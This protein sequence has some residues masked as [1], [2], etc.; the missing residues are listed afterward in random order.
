MSD[1]DERIAKLP[2]WAREH[3]KR[4]TDAPET[5]RRTLVETNA[6]LAHAN[7][8]IRTVNDRLDAVHELLKCAARGG[9]ETARAYVDR[10]VAE[11]AADS[12]R[13][14]RI[15]A[16]MAHVRAVVDAVMQHANASGGVN[17]S[18]ILDR[19]RDIQTELEPDLEKI[20]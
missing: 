16:V 8:Q 2:T 11:Y 3:I 14:A 4:L 19:M 15:T 1:L 20:S 10:I 13:N 17:P 5:I 12:T 6:K 7:A 9:H 18:F